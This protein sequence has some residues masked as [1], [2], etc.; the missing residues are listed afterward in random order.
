MCMAVQCVSSYQPGRFLETVCRFDEKP[1]CFF[2]G[3]PVLQG[4]LAFHLCHHERQFG[5]PRGL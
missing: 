5:A 2:L 1:V 4:K 3:P